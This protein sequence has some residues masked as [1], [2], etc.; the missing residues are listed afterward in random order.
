[1]LFSIGSV[2]Q[3]RTRNVES[4]I[5]RFIDVK[6][7]EVSCAQVSEECAAPVRIVI[8]LE[9]NK[10]ARRQLVDHSRKINTEISPVYTSL[11]NGI[12]VTEDK[13]PLVS[14]QC[15]VYSFKYD[16]CDTGCVGYACHQLHQTIEE[17]NAS[18][19][20]TT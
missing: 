16:V 4:T 20:V 9:V 14:Q 10:V 12:R 1:M 5:R 8:S 18:V 19:L 3:L 13:P 2:A 7:L 11:K 15:V 6:V 17:D